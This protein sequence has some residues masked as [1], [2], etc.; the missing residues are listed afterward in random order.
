MGEQLLEKARHALRLVDEL[1]EDAER[2]K[3]G[4][5]GNVRLGF[6]DLMAVD[7]V[8]LLA[9]VFH[10]DYPDVELDLMGSYTTFEEVELLLGGQLDAALIHGRVNQ[11]RLAMRILRQDR[12][13][14]VF[15]EKHPLAAK[16][17]IE[18]GDLADQP[19]ILYPENTGS[20]IRPAVIAMCAAAGFAPRVVREVPESMTIVALAASGVGVALLPEPLTRFQ[21]TGTA[22]RPLR[23]QRH[24]LA[25]TLAWR[26]G[27]MSPT[28]QKLLESVERLGPDLALG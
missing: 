6:T 20:A 5:I 13:Y 11:P 7:I 28:V 14:A 27:D 16:H 22:F 21:P 26:R 10:Q 9:Q 25:A 1:V 12:M 23:G 3:R 4:E 24:H 15:G 18:I 19:F 17:E 2:A 8:P